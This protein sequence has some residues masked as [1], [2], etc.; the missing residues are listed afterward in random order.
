MVRILIRNLH[1]MSPPGWLQDMRLQFPTTFLILFVLMWTARPS[2]K[3]SA[4]LYTFLGCQHVL[5]GR[6]CMFLSV[7]I[8]DTNLAFIHHF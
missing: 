1:S 8:F 2:L 4:V 7:L 5:L 3:R 6:R